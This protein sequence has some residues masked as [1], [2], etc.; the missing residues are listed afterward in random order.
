MSNRN[1]GVQNN[2]LFISRIETTDT[3]SQFMEKVNN[4]FSKLIENNGGPTGDKGDMG[5]Q[6]APTK[7][8][9]PIHVW[10]INEDYSTEI[11]YGEDFEIIGYGDLADVKYQEGHLILLENAHVYK[12]GVDNNTLTP[13]YI[14][15]LQSY[16]PSSVVDGKTAYIHFKYEDENNLSPNLI[17]NIEKKDC[18]GIYVDYDNN[19][20]MDNDTYTWIK[21]NYKDKEIPLEKL[22]LNNIDNIELANTKFSNKLFSKQVTSSAGFIVDSLNTEPENNKNKVIIGG[23]NIKIINDDGNTSTLITSDYITDDEFNNTEF[24]DTTESDT[25]EYNS[26]EINTIYDDVSLSSL[27]SNELQLISPYEEIDKNLQLK[28][29]NGCISIINSNNTIGSINDGDI[30]IKIEYFNES[31]NKWEEHYFEIYDKINY[32]WDGSN[33]IIFNLEINDDDYS[34][35]NEH[36]IR[37]KTIINNIEYAGEDKNVDILLTTNYTYSIYNTEDYNNNN[38]TKIGKNGIIVR[39]NNED[40]EENYY[41]SEFHVSKDEILMKVG[42]FGLKITNEGIFKIIDGVEESLLS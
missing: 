9:V 37:F 21:I 27:S 4:N 12:L 16:D 6:G 25:T 2:E 14:F 41:K 13:K 22:D 7:P 33:Y 20:P 38:T 18:I 34:V 24:D 3:I 15:T 1:N 11:S 10:K 42:T 8:K 26:N 31:E 39:L 5:V 19:K 17:P 23:N 32:V 35:L 28:S 30:D 36:R 40:N 29:I